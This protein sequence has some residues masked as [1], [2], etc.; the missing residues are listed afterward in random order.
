ML[1][2]APQCNG[3]LNQSGHVDSEFVDVTEKSRCTLTMTT[4]K[5]S[6]VAMD[7]LETRTWTGEVNNVQGEE[8]KGWKFNG[9]SGSGWTMLCLNQSRSSCSTSR[10]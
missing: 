1:V 8:E 10:I 4:T 3:D 7:T 2:I 5:T 6:T 9:T